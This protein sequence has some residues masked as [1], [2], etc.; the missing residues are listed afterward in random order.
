MPRHVS[1]GTCD[2][3]P[4]KGTSPRFAQKAM[5]QVAKS[6]PKV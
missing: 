6:H 4:L 2:D 1:A 3:L 5:P